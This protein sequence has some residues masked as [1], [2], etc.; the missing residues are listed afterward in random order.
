M[1]KHISSVSTIPDPHHQLLP[2]P[3]VE[4]YLAFFF[5]F[6]FFNL[7]S[8]FPIFFSFQSCSFLNWGNT[9]FLLCTPGL[10]V[11]SVAFHCSPIHLV[12]S[13]PNHR[14]MTAQMMKCSSNIKLMRNVSSTVLKGHRSLQHS[15]LR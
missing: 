8:R 4:L 1:Y 14:N 3:L 13:W 2:E 7:L 10:S 5:D 9:F 15:L 12:S 11:C 6:L